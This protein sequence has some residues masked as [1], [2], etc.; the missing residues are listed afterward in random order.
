VLG[1]YLPIGRLR[2]IWEVNALVGSLSYNWIV[3]GL[4]AVSIAL[5][6][7]L[8]SNPQIQTAYGWGVV[9]GGL[10]LPA[11][12]LAL[13]LVV[14][15]FYVVGQ[16]INV[17][18]VL[19]ASLVNWLRPGIVWLLTP[20]RWLVS[21]V[22]IPIGRLIAIPFVWLWDSLLK[23]IVEVLTWPLVWLGVNIFRPVALLILKYVVTPVAVAMAVVLGAGLALAPF[24]AVGRVAIRSFQSA[25]KGLLSPQGAFEQGVGIGFICLDATTMAVLNATWSIGITPALFLLLA[26]A[27]PVVYFVRA[28]QT[29][30]E[31][32][33]S[34]WTGM[35]LGSRVK[36][37]LETSRLDAVV[38][39]A[40]LP[41][42]VV[43]YLFSHSE[44]SD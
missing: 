22:I 26:A 12:A 24:A 25:F 32:S 7:V 16:V 30:G 5:Y 27:V 34:E 35:D 10:S 6:L 28:G 44:A 31:W 42:A 13:S 23:G 21:H 43:L 37:Y 33:V 38:A 4:L 9:V 17:I 2:P 3:L 18:A 39:C 14:A 36:A 19:L 41:L 40:L 8:A 1:V 20:F 29:R 11:I 15:A